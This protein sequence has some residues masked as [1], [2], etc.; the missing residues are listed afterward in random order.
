MI[1][2]D[3]E[4]IKRGLAGSRTGDSSRGSVGSGMRK[5]SFRRKQERSIYQM[6]RD[7]LE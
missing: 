7:P 3:L 4:K 6:D 2:L 5:A 1:P